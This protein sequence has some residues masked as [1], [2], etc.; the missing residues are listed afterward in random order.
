[1]SRARDTLRQLLLTE[2]AGEE[3]DEDMDEA[4]ATQRIEELR[5]VTGRGVHER[6]PEE[7]VETA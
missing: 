7:P 6:D 1:V 3:F 4:A 5:T 2:E